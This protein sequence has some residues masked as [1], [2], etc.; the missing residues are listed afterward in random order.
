MYEA[1]NLEHCDTEDQRLDCVID[2]AFVNLGAMMAERVDGKV[3]VEVDV[4][5]AK[6]VSAIV[7]KARAV[8]TFS[9][10]LSS[11]MSWAKHFSSTH[12][13]FRLQ[14]YHKVLLIPARRSKLE[15]LFFIS[16][17]LT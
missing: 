3:S 5:A 16:N 7:D 12:F 17:F 8:C 14:L 11:A 1:C 10:F 4:H 2:K 15:H 6:D 13:F 9:F